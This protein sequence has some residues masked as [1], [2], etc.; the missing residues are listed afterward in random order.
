M[1]APFLKA[2]LAVEDWFSGLM[3]TAK[4]LKSLEEDN[5]KLQAEIDRYVVQNTILKND[6][7][8]LE[9]LQELYEVGQLLRELP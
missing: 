8:K 6:A 1:A 2:Y 9:E 4:R 3:T 5:E 7:A